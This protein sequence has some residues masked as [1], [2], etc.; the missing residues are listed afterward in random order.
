MNPEKLSTIS[1]ASQKPYTLFR[2][3]KRILIFLFISL[4]L[5]LGAIFIAGYIYQNEVKEYVIKQ[6]NEQLNTQ[7]IIDAKDIDFTVLQNFPHASVDFKNI[8]VMEV[9]ESKNKDTL[10]KAGKVSFFFNL[11]DIFNKNY[12]L[13]KIRMDDLSIKIKINKNGKDNYHFWKT[14]S[15]KDST[16]FSFALENVEL[17]KIEVSYIDNSTN[18]NINLFIIKSIISG[19][20]SKEKYT[21]QTESEFIVNLIKYDGLTLLS[22][23]NILTAFDLDINNT[24]SSYTI[25]KGEIKIEKI[26]FEVIGSISNANNESLVN[27]GINGKNIDIQSLLSL[28]PNQYKVKIKDYKSAGE[29]YFNATVK[30]SVARGLAPD[31]KADFGINNAEIT[32]VEE[33]IVLRQVNLKGRYISEKKANSNLSLFELNPFSARIDQGKISGELSI[34]NFENPK[35]SAKLIADIS[36]GNLQHLIKIDAI[37]KLTGQIKIDASFNGEG[38]AFNS[39]NYQNISTKGNLQISDVSMK[40]KNNALMLTNFNGQFKFNNSDLEVEKLDGSIS[41][42]DFELKGVF[43]NSIDYMLKENQDIT[44][45]A[46]LFSK[47]ID[48]N[49][50]LAN[51]NENVKSKS[52]YKLQFSEHIN[53]ILNSEIKH[54]EFREFEAFNINGLVKLEQKKMNLERLSLSTM[55]GNINTSGLIDG[56]DSTKILISCVSEAT[57]INIDKMFNAFENFGGT[58][59]TD[60][61]IKGSADAEIKL[62]MELSP[63]LEIDLEKLSAEVDLKIENGELNNVE[64]MK[65]LSRFID[66]KEL[67]NIRFETLK[68]KLE[69]KNK[70]ISMPKME[71]LSSALNL[72][73]YGTHTFNNEIN[74]KIKLSLNDLLSKKAKRAK[75]QNDEFGTIAD[76]GLGRTD[77]FLSMTGTVDNPIIKYDPKSAIQSIKQD[78]KAEKQTLKSILKEEFGLF[79]KDTAIKN[80]VKKSNDKN[81][82]F[83]IKWDEPKADEKKTELKKPK[84]EE[85]D[86]F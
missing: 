62:I 86:D 4:A 28:I 65:S 26:L 6:L 27:I 80:K 41:H 75:K 5:I 37:E 17:N 52:N 42:S 70:K 25:K 24:I 10:F 12:H 68:N 71:I 22:K 38:N 34:S 47:N 54:I 76:D 46:K 20:F 30:G 23:K 29:F 61:N 21:L 58:T 79:K 15:V 45:E 59:I 40:F 39:T 1:N 13:K 63:E 66:L 51:N 57:G 33:D 16:S 78:L 48:L 7:L 43:R 3:L 32:Q 60:K 69:I 84:K 49:E 31:I 72:T 53:L 44:V 36:L 77:I 8:K 9:V 67:E 2:Y 50:L 56:S 74:Y 11:I 18:K 64:S 35:V 55:N 14:S 73:A 19:N 83:I 81:T 82:K 85:Q